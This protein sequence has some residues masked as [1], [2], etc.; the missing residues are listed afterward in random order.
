MMFRSCYS[1]IAICY[2]KFM[3]LVGALCFAFCNELGF[4]FVWQGKGVDARGENTA[5]IWVARI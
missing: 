3:K 4:E 1:E 5:K 2:P